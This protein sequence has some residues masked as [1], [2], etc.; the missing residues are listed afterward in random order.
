MFSL[1]RVQP[2]LVQLLRAQMQEE[3]KRGLS[4]DV[5]PEAKRDG[6]QKVRPQ[7]KREAMIFQE[8]GK[9]MARTLGMT[10]AWKTR[11]E[12]DKI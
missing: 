3:H 9:I 11:Q 5:R 1:P 6:L 12:H 10:R 4:S 8:H 7:A 2:P